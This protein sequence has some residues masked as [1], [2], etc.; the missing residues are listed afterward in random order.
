MRKR[1][2]CCMHGRGSQNR[3]DLKVF[4][5]VLE[6]IPG[7]WPTP[8]LKLRSLSNDL[9]DAWAKL[10]FFNA[11]SNS[12]KDRAVWNM[13]VRAREKGELRN[14]LYE[15]SS[16]N[17]AISLAAI[18]NALSIRT[19]VFLPKFVHKYTEV[20]L[21]ILGA[22]VV[23]TEFDA[24][25]RNF[26]ERVKRM[27][28]LDHAM[29][30]NQFE[31]DDNFEA[32]YRYTAP[33]IDEQLS[34]VGKSPPK[35]IVCGVGTSGHI[36]GISKYFKEKYGDVKIVGVVPR[37]GSVIPGIKRLESGPKWFYRV[38]VDEVVEVET[39]EAIREVINMARVEGLLIGLSSGAVVSAY[40]RVRDSIGPGTYV[41]VFPDSIYKYVDLVGE[42]LA[43]LDI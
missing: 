37:A 5:S 9:Y 26:V 7:V 2:S 12:V 40:K 11:M 15:A 13:V 27:A 31:N 21:R 1:G 6:L 33:E 29:N 32:H 23:R 22:E 4:E 38:K 43:K 19:R 20:L 17:V 18:G 10:E 24:I 30:L 8:M 35:A 42:A 39:D 3:S 25:D 14:I 34:A 41:L 28:E 36:A 16:G